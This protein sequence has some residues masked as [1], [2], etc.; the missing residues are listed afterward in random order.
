MEANPIHLV[1]WIVTTFTIWQ[2]ESEHLQME[3]LAFKVEESF[4]YTQPTT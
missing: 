1:A 3:T 4:P 2:L